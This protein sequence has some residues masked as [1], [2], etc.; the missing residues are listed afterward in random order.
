MSYVLIPLLKALFKGSATYRYLYLWKQDLGS[1]TKAIERVCILIPLSALHIY[2][3][4]YLI[5]PSLDLLVDLVTFIY[6]F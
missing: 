6:S 1:H 2:Y 4:P 5:S 3:Y